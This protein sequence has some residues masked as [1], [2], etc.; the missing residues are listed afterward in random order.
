M[1]C[2]LTEA[3]KVCVTLAGTK[4]M[5]KRCVDTKLAVVVSVSE[6]ATYYFDILRHK[7]ICPCCMIH[8]PYL[9][10]EAI[11]GL[12]TPRTTYAS[13]TYNCSEYDYGLRFC[14]YAS[15]IDPQCHSDEHVAGVRCREGESL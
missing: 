7:I 14:N 10:A 2:A 11:S 3:M 6:K 8:V 13:R 5:L 15:T 9:V 1:K 4:M 12:G